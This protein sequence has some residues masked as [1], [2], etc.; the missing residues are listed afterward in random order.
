MRRLLA[1]FSIISITAFFGGRFSYA[2][3]AGATAP[4]TGIAEG[5]WEGSITLKQIVPAGTGGSESPG[6]LSSGLRLKIL[7][8]GKGALMDITEQSMFGYP[9][10]EVSWNAASIRFTLD[11]LGPGEELACEGI[12]SASAGTPG[13]GGAIIGTA[14]A[15]SWK[16]SFLLRRVPGSQAPHEK[17]ISIPIGEDFLPGTLLQ[18]GGAQSRVPLVLLLPG[19]GTSDRDGNNYNVPG[20]SNTLS[21]LAATLYDKGVASFRYDKR[22]SGEAYLLE[23]QGMTTSLAVH[24]SDAARIL[25]YLLNLNMFS[26]IIVA[27]MNEGAWTGAAA[28]N[29]LAEEGIFIDG[30]VVLDGSGV[31]PRKELEASIQEL[32]DSTR[33]EAEAIV[34]ALM[35]GKP[36]PAP[37]AQLSD[38]FSPTRIEWLES[39]LKFDPSSEIAKV[40]APILFIYGSADL[41]ISREAFERLLKARPNAAARL[42]PSMNYLLKQVKTEEENYD[43]FTNPGYPLAEGLVDLITAFAK[44]KPLPPGSA[45]LPY[46]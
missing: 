10:D 3:S 37:S 31:E 7:G 46:K 25:K 36:F 15:R 16:G 43:S 11:A 33:K 27:G 2:Q 9:L 32:D 14:K 23:R 44:A 6:S 13:L 42:I 22:G 12:F 40:Q 41:Q 4:A 35:A 39:W 1:I 19:A 5:L 8:Q 18:P 30:I 26:R 38:F 34:Q 45:A 17:I 29:S 20:K 21:M 24:A 28:I